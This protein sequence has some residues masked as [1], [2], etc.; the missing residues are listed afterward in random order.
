MK[1]PLEGW[2]WMIFLMKARAA[3]GGMV[4]G[5]GI[6]GV[7]IFGGWGAETVLD[8][9]ALTAPV[10]GAGDSTGATVCLP[11]LASGLGGVLG[12]IGVELVVLVSSLALEVA[13]GLPVVSVVG[14]TSVS[15][16]EPSSEVLDSL[17]KDENSPEN[18]WKIAEIFS[19]VTDTDTDTPSQ[20]TEDSLLSSKLRTVSDRFG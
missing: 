17:P 20:G 19:T 12:A 3:L 6:S 16:L 5:V 18:F 15:G 1:A 7:F 8:V 14:S 4:G 11:G 2:Y 9:G 13:G 10:P